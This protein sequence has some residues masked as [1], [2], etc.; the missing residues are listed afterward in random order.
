M[1]FLAPMVFGSNR[2]GTRARR[3]RRR[4]RLGGLLNYYAR[5]VMRCGGRVRGLGSVVGH[6]GF[7]GRNHA[8]WPAGH[9]IRGQ[10]S[11]EAEMDF[12]KSSGN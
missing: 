3:I 7:G 8:A 12:S 10:Q 9:P 4:Q 1:G 5:G 2:Q 6:Y 11:L